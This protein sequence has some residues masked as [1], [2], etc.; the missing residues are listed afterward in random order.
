MNKTLLLLLLVVLLAGGGIAFAQAGAGNA[1]FG[2]Q[3]APPE[4]VYEE[5]GRDLGEEISQ[6]AQERD[7]DFDLEGIIPEVA[8]EAR[9][10]E[11]RGAGTEKGEDERSPVAEAVLEVL[12][13]G[14]SPED[15][16]AFGQAVSEQARGNEDGRGLGEA[17]S[18]AARE[19]NQSMG[20]GNNR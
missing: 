17:V 15:G 1:L 13:N 4:V 20:A 8:E 18:K 3:S 6:S 2:L 7:T 11:N 10:N 19:A 5:D 14:K 12:G 9:A 16:R